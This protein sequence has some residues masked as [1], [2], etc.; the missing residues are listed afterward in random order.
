MSTKRIAC[1]ASVDVIN[2]IPYLL[3]SSFCIELF[4]LHVQISSILIMIIRVILATCFLILEHCCA[5]SSPLVSAMFN[6]NPHGRPMFICAE[7]P[8][9]PARKIRSTRA[10]DQR[11]STQLSAGVH[12]EQPQNSSEEVKFSVSCTVH[13]YL[14]GSQ[15]QAYR[16]HLLLPVRS[17]CAIFVYS[18][19][20]L[21]RTK[22]LTL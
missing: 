19:D 3:L 5:R 1:I 15:G 20:V 7:N 18:R 22:T 9:P 16:V 8:H 14:R 12:A 4:I 2:F 17:L 6:L 11:R 13:T 21:Q 10:E